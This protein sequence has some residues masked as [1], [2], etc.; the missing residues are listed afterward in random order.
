MHR[1]VPVSIALVALGVHPESV[2][3]PSSAPEVIVYS[4]YF[5]ADGMRF[6]SVEE[7]REYLLNAPRDFFGVFFRDCAAKGREQELMKLISEVLF[8][9]RAQRGER[10]SVELGSGSV[11]CP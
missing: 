7:L 1:A 11:P 9:R 3:E 8:K 4:Q 6:E 10:G 2:A 5:E